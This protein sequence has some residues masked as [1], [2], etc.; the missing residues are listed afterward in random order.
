[1]RSAALLLLAAVSGTVSCGD[2]EESEYIPSG[3][4]TIELGLYS[5]DRFVEFVPGDSCPIVAGTQG[6]TWIMP[7]VRTRGLGL[8]TTLLASLTT[9]LGETVA[10]LERSSTF[11]IAEDGWLE[12]RFV[13]MHVRR[14]EMHEDELLSDLYGQRA[15]L[16]MVI[17]DE[18]QRTV[19]GEVELVLID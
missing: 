13:A 3:P 16:R 10:A 15:T 4:S 8:T 11:G 17:T 1:M 9:E 18:Q 2:V 19:S 12:L 7:A 14:D 5:G 6:G